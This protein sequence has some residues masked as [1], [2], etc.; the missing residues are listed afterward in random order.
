MPWPCYKL[1]DEVTS[2][3]A[4]VS[5]TNSLIKLVIKGEES[6]SGGKNS[7]EKTCQVRAPPLAMPSQVKQPTPATAV[8]TLHGAR[9]GAQIISN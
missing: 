2:S 7:G 1:F 3:N 9:Y 6:E 4:K 5:E 8:K